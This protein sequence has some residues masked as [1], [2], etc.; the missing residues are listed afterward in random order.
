MNK[1]I[2]I[3]IITFLVIFFASF[4]WFEFYYLNSSV[5]NFYKQISQ[6]NKEGEVIIIF[7][8]GGWGVTPPEEAFD[9]MPLVENIKKNIEDFGL[10]AVVVP[11]YRT[12]DNFFAKLGQINEF[13]TLFFSQS[14]KMAKCLENFIQENSD[15][16][17]L[18]VGLSNGATFVDQ[19][20]KKIPENMESS[21]FGI[22]IGPPFWAKPTDLP[23]VIF[24]D[25]NGKDPLSAGDIPTLL[26]SLFKNP[27]QKIKIVE[28]NY[29]WEDIQNEVTNFLEQKL[30]G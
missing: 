29:S 1:K 5:E 8:P 21:V 26:V 2:K 19:T 9:L 4:I 25:K 3:S 16:N 18:M 11:Y 24:F 15:S 7:N 6:A 30:K 27:F 20:I 10:N 23:N 22:E 28:H 12:R 14:K 13:F 17:I